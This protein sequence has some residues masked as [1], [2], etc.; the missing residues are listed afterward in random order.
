MPW[1]P[2]ANSNNPRT[3][4]PP[5]PRTPTGNFFWIR[6]CVAHDSMSWKC[7]II[8][9]NVCY[10]RENIVVLS[11]CTSPYTVCHL[12]LRHC[13]LYSSKYIDSF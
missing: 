12:L 2:L 8:D 1:T 10:I 7:E 5:P 13:L 9:S 6:A 11:S 4:L 3:P